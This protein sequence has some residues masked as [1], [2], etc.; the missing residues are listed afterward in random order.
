MPNLDKIPRK[1]IDAAQLEL[2]KLCDKYK[3]SRFQIISSSHMKQKWKALIL[4]MC[5]LDVPDSN[6]GRDPDKDLEL[7]GALAYL[8]FD[9]C[10]YKPQ[11]LIDDIIKQYSL[12]PKKS[13]PITQSD[14]RESVRTAR[15]K[16]K[17][18]IEELSS[19]S[20]GNKSNPDTQKLLEELKRMM[21]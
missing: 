17:K 10:G 20:S 13:G 11:S 19:K 12:K 7:A 5:G 15:K 3:I 4:R 2:D 14:L 16:Y 6:R 8:Y 21:E 1:E 18:K 9:L